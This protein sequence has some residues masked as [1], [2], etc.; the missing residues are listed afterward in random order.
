MELYLDLAIYESTL[1]TLFIVVN[2]KLLVVLALD[3]FRSVILGCVLYWRL[4]AIDVAA[5]AKVALFD[6]S[7]MICLFPAMPV[8]HII[9]KSS[10]SGA[11]TPHSSS[12]AASMADRRLTT[13]GTRAPAAELTAPT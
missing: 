11:V 12:E 6:C 5:N 4:V 3:D 7:C 10:G 1:A 9:A 13:T 2:F 8:L